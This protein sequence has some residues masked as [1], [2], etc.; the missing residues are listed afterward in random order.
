MV[1]RGLLVF[2]F[3]IGMVLLFRRTLLVATAARG[4]QTGRPS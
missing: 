3:T 2:V 1:I 4:M